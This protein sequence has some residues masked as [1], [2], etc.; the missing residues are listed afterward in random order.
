LD[1]ILNEYQQISGF[2]K[3]LYDV[4]VMLRKNIKIFAL[5]DKISGHLAGW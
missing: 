4:G 3:K 2:N 5:S 1:K